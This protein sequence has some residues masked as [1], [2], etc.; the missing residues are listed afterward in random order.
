M[1]SSPYYDNPYWEFHLPI[2]PAP[3]PEKDLDMDG[4]PY[5]YTGNNTVE[6]HNWMD[7][8]GNA[9]YR[10]RLPIGLNKYLIDKPCRIMAVDDEEDEE[11][12]CD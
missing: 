10:P 12:D 2:N 6:L 4:D 11:Y 3:D 5:I 7:E 8:A 1:V 9:T